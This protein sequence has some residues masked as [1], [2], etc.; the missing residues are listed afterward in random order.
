MRLGIMLSGTR[1]I[2]ETIS[3]AQRAE[4]S[5][6]ADIW[7]SEDYFERGA[8]T[9]ASAVASS[10]ETL[11]IGIGVVNPWT[12]HPMLTAMEFA[13]LNEIA[14]GRALLGIGASNRVWIQDRC[15][16]T[17]HT[18]LQCIEE[19]TQIIRTALTGEHVSV[20]G[21]HFAVDAKLSFN[22]T[23]K[24]PAIYIGA[25][26]PKALNLTG[27]IG[28]G[29]LLSLLS[30]SEYIS[31]ARRQCGP[32]L[33]TAAYVLAACSPDDRH[34]ARSNVQYTLS[35]F[36]G[37]HGDHKITRMSGI[38]P[39]LATE[40]HDRWLAG[41]P[42]EELINDKMIDT[43]AV[44]G[45]TMDCVNRLEQLADAGL[46]SAVFRDPGNVGIDGLFTVAAAYH[47]N[48]LSMS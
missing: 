42:A 2:P 41:D 17:F 10:T 30:S 22:P 46:D 8:F 5:G 32:T 3:I 36:L 44:A 19:S 38:D 40:F 35:R 6:F 9:I 31:W 34:S 48:E 15:G 20:E 12:R 11:Q 23:H 13:A 4:A 27:R 14:N 26:G 29:A 43:F 28:N 24:D 37:V 21:Q 7:I 47:R 33:D 16:I 25:K 45:N 39:E 18:P 1:P